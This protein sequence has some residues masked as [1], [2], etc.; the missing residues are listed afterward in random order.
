MPPVTHVNKDFFKA[1]FSGEK[2]A[3]KVT[4]V[5]HIIVPKLDEMKMETI[6]KMIEP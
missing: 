1:L 3:V 4:Q 2:K 5:T 6:L